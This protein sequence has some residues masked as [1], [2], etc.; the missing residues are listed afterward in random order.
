MEAA[1][2]ADFSDVR[3]R[4]G[5]EASSI[6]ALAFTVGSRIF[7]AQGQY[8]P[9]TVQG[10]M[11][12]GHELA[13]VLQQRA[14]RVSNPFGRGL[15]VVRDPVLENEAERLGMRAAMSVQPFRPAVPAFPPLPPVGG[16]S[17][18]VQRAT[19]SS[20]R[21]GGRDEDDNS[22]RKTYPKLREIEKKPKRTAARKH[23]LIPVRDRLTKRQRSRLGV[24][25]DDLPVW[26]NYTPVRD[27]LGNAIWDGRRDGLDFSASVKLAMAATKGGGCQIQKPGIC[28]GAANSIDHVEDFVTAQSSL[29]RYVICDGQNHWTACYKED[30]Q[31]CYDAGGDTSG[32]RW[33]CTQCNSSKGGARG[34][35]ENQPVWIERCP[36][37]CG[38]S[39]KGQPASS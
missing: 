24:N 9:D 14:G 7:F 39:F 13:H 2:G 16:P 15:A 34:R 29:P 4:V 12:I 31:D 23:K 25:E 10:R 28:T 35:Y 21:R 19:F 32:L 3:V 30:A 5:P 26:P 11:L 8:T 22:Y 6:G 38:Y 36:G 37:D 18:A 1:F 17:Q 27:A 33:S 20:S